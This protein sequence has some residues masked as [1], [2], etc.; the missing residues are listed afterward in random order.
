[1][2][3]TD[4]LPRSKFQI[5]QRVYIKDNYTM[6]VNRDIIYIVVQIM[7]TCLSVIRYPFEKNEPYDYML[8]EENHIGECDGHKYMIWNCKE[9]FMEGIE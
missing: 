5:G 4:K 8:I 9:S 6:K 1:M 2:Q 7:L 3:I